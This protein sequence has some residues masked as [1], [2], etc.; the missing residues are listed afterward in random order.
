MSLHRRLARPRHR[1]RLIL[2]QVLGFPSALEVSAVPPVSPALPGPV[3][4]VDGWN[5]VHSAEP[6]IPARHARS[7]DFDMLPGDEHTRMS[8]VLPA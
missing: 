2:R 4:P 1:A 8:S 3:A 5:D 6:L 7:A